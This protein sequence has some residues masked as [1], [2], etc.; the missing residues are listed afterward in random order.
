[1]AHGQLGEA[2]TGI[3]AETAV[4]ICLQTIGDIP[5]QEVRAQSGGRHH[6]MQALPFLPPGGGR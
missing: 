2:A 3:G 4:L 1:M 6:A 5:L